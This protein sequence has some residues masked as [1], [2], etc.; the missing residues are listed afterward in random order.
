MEMK[1]RLNLRPQDSLVLLKLVSA[2]KSHWRQV[3]LAQD[4]GLSQSEIA[5]ALVRLRR[6][7]LVNDEKKKALRLATVD[8][9]LYGLKYF[10]PAEL[11][12]L[13]RGMP[14]GH[15]AKPLKGRLIVEDDSEWVWP[16]PDG[17]VRGIALLPIYETAPFAAKKD[18]ALYELLALVDSV[19]AGGARERKLAEE[20]FRKRLLPG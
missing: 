15:S 16:D 11:G 1:G 20:A 6:A 19:R 17:K 9:T 10:Y 3:D 14:T 18:P 13:V 5:N 2:E 12:S 4:L 7:G 8:F